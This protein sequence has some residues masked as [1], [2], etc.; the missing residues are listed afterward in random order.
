MVAPANNHS[1][2]TQSEVVTGGNNTTTPQQQQQQPTYNQPTTGTGTVTGQTGS[3][4]ASNQPEAPGT[5]EIT[6]PNAFMADKVSGLYYRSLMWDR[7]PTE[8]KNNAQWVYYDYERSAISDGYM[9]GT[10]N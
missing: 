1:A 4:L 9:L 5:E 10:L 8:I 3:S 7:I 2:T 6:E